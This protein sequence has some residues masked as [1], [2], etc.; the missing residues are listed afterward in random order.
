MRPFV[1]VLEWACLLAI[2][3]LAAYLRF[4]NLPS[5]PGWYS[6]E[7]TVAEIARHFGEGRQQYFALTGSVLLTGRVPLFPLLVSALTRAGM[8]GLHAARIL[9]ACSSL[10]AVLLV[11][12]LGRSS[13]DGRGGGFGLLAAFLLAVDAQAVIYNRMGFSYNLLSPLILGVVLALWRFLQGGKRSWLALA[14]VLIGI[15]T[16]TDLTGL[17]FMLVMALIVSVIRR[18]DLL[19]SLPLSL[20]PLVVYSAVMLLQAPAAFIYDLGFTLPRFSAIPWWA[21]FAVL[22]ANLGAVSREHPWFLPSVVGMFLW[23]PPK[24]QRL[25]MVMFLGPMFLLGRTTALGGHQ[26]YHMIPFFPFLAVGV[27]GLLWAGAPVALAT[28]NRGFSTLLAAWGLERLGGRGLWLQSRLGAIGAALGVFALAMSPILVPVF[29]T[30][31]QVRTG[32]RTTISHLLVDADDARQVIVYLNATASPNALTIASPA[33]G[34]ALD[35]RVVDFQLAVAAEGKAPND[36]PGDIPDDRFSFDARLDAAD[37]VIIDPIWVNWAAVFI[38]E[39]DEIVRKVRSWPM[40]FQAGEIQVF[41]N[42]DNLPR[43]GNQRWQ[44]QAGGPGMN[45]GERRN[46]ASWATFRTDWR[47]PWVWWE[48]WSGALSHPIEGIPS[49]VAAGL[50]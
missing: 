7:G 29:S 26:Q 9:A 25:M 19:W 5:N 40:V 12:V 33:I 20:S 22:V 13:L 45:E 24:W 30:F 10:L 38:P 23:R 6:D 16:V 34:W 49:D 31:D 50:S 14:S 17:S 32:F 41:Q 42:P 4:A 43:S 44:D 39:V 18:R 28:L 47:Q 27:A 8:D 2:V 46:P 3:G 37:R 1:P 36:F 11:Y 48:S 35:G 21:Q 15:A